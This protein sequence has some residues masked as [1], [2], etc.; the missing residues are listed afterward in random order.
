MNVST[1]LFD[2]APFS[3]L[4][5]LCAMTSPVW[6]AC[7]VS[8]FVPNKFF[9]LGTGIPTALSGAFIVSMGVIAFVYGSHQST[10][11]A[12]FADPQQAAIIERAGHDQATNALLLLAPIGL[13][14]LVLGSVATA[15]GARTSRFEKK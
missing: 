10:M 5:V 7:V 8:L 11:A 2:A 13:L 4:A 15:L 6:I 3:F 12:R 14:P 1:I 9:R